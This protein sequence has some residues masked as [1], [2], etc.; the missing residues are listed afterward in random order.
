[1]LEKGLH[2]F[3]MAMAVIYTA[4]GVF[5]LTKPNALKGIV[6]ESY[7]PVIGALILVYGFYRGYKEYIVEKNNTNK[8]L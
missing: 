4:I 2:Y 3:R 8:D 7:A 5:I 6:D 1:M